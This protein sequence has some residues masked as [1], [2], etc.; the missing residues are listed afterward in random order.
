MQY[1][2]IGGCAAGLCAI[3]GIRKVDVSGNIILVSKENYP[4]YARCLITEYLIGSYPEKSLYLR[5]TSFYERNNV[6]LILGKEAK[7]IL[8]DEKKVVLNGDR[9]ITY[10]K[11]LIATGSSPKKLGIKGEEKYGVFGFR[12]IEDV[13]EIKEISRDANK[14][15]VFGGG[16]IGMKAGYALKKLGIEVEVII[17]SSHILSQVVN[18]EAAIILARWIEEHGI[19]I[20]TGIEPVEILGNKKMEGVLLDNGEKTEAQI[21]IIGKGIAPNILQADSNIATSYGIIVDDYMQTS[22]P[23]IYAAGDVAEAKDIITGENT[24]NAMWLCAKEQGKTAGINMAGE[25]KQYPGSIGAN[26]AEF[27][28]LPFISFG[29]TR[30]IKNVEIKEIVDEKKPIYKR[31]VLRNNRLIGCVLIGDVKAAG[32]YMALVRA[33]SNLEKDKE[34]LEKKWFDY[35]KVRKLLEKTDGFRKSINPE[36]E[37][38]FFA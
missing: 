29:K 33:K 32:L 36:G 22:I 15:I 4:P 2:I 38:F 30:E 26:A 25:K 10:D 3:E 24:V 6:D 23:D 21:G 28:G 1:I 18:K 20:R 35:G 9:T 19:K 17:K 12:T 11:L 27:F 7:K 5:D 16:L 37:V 13:K 14:A 8:I 31:F 34:I